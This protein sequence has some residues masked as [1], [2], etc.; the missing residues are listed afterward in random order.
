MEIFTQKGM[1]IHILFSQA[2]YALADTFSKDLHRVK[3]CTIEQRDLSDH[4][5][6]TMTNYLKLAPKTP[7]G[8]LT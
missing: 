7:Y 2:W 3:D 4:S 5:R 1:Q 8:G 6:L